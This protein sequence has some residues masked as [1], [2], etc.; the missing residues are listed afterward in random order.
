LRAAFE[1]RGLVLPLLVAPTTPAA[2]AETIA[3]ASSGF[4]YLVSRLGVTSAS[5]EPDFAWIAERVAALRRVTDLPLAIG[6]GISTA[7]HVRR[8]SEIAD[9]AIVGSALIDAYVGHDPSEA[10]GRVRAFLTG[11]RS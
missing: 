5:K 8:A 3:K 9:G 1:P 10:A 6:F 4:V 7:A 2:R 11:L